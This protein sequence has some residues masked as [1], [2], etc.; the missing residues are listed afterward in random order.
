MSIS[1]LTCRRGW[2]TSTLRAIIPLHFISDCA[3]TLRA[4]LRMQPVGVLSA[5]SASAFAH[6]QLVEVLTTMNAL[7]VRD[8]IMVLDVPR[9]G[10]DAVQVSRDAAIAPALSKVLSALMQS[11]PE[12][13]PLS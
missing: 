9:R 12:V 10:A 3:F 7:M 4:S 5:S 6:P 2:Q 11:G 1:T 8:A 13:V